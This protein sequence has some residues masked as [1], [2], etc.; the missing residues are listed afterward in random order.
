MS[1]LADYRADVARYTSYSDHAAARDIASQQGLWALL[2]YRL[3][4]AVYRSS[5]APSIRLPLLGALYGWRKLIEVTT[6]IS[7]PHTAAIGPGLYIGH[8]GPIVFNKDTVMGATCDVHQGVTIGASDRAGRSG[9]P[10]I[11]DRVWIGPNATVAGPITI[12]DHVMISANSLVARDVPSDTVVRGV[13]AE[14]VG[15][16]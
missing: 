10:R 6:G 7:L 11:G 13:P 16:R 5:L 12:G 2:Q 3:A 4:A 8:F 1:W 14:I 9:V 15:P